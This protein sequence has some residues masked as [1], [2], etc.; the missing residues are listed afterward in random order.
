MRWPGYRLR[1]SIGPS[2][3]TWDTAAVAWCSAL[4]SLISLN[5]LLPLRLDRIVRC[6]KK[7]IIVSINKA[8][9]VTSY[10]LPVWSNKSVL[11]FTVLGTSLPCSSPPPTECRHPRPSQRVF[12]PDSTHWYSEPPRSKSSSST[13]LSMLLSCLTCST[14]LTSVEMPSGSA[15]HSYLLQLASMIADEQLLYG[16]VIAVASPLKWLR[17]ASWWLLL[18]KVSFKGALC[19]SFPPRRLLTWNLLEVV[20][21]LGGWMAFPH[22]AFCRQ[23]CFTICL[24]APWPSFAGRVRSMTTSLKVGSWEA[25]RCSPCWARVVHWAHSNHPVGTLNDLSCSQSSCCLPFTF[26]VVKI[27]AC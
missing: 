10:S 7:Q 22:L 23:F 4:L 21:E 27:G 8:F 1:H 17:F 14:G 5:S 24:Q 12:Q 3:S 9:M 25:S 6:N 26:T 20:L 18:L 19:L 13:W 11:T 15:S 2:T 16:Y